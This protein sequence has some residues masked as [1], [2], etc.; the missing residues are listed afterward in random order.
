M[1]CYGRPLCSTSYSVRLLQ[2]EGAPQIVAHKQGLDGVQGHRDATSFLR[3]QHCVTDAELLLRV[4]RF[5]SDSRPMEGHCTGWLKAGW[6]LGEGG[7]SYDMGIGI[8]DG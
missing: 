7:L 4:P 6:G 2:Q 3:L 8:F 1:N 5:Q